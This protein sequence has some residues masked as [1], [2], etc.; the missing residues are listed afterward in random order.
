[1]ESM[2]KQGLATF[3]ELDNVPFIYLCFQL[4]YFR[5]VL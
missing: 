3:F 1:M 2:N 4:E 5:D